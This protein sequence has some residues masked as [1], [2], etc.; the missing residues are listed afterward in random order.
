MHLS[1]SLSLSLLGMESSLYLGNELTRYM[2]HLLVIIYSV[3]HVSPRL[4]S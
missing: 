4:I 1:L 2:R 3:S